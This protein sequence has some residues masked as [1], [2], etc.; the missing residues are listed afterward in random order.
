MRGRLENVEARL[1]EETGATPNMSEEKLREYAELFNGT[2]EVESFLF[3][4]DPHT[5]SLNNLTDIETKVSS[6][7]TLLREYY[8]NTPTSFAMCTGDWIDDGYTPEQACFNIGLASSLMRAWFDRCCYAVGNHEYNDCGTEVLTRQ[9]VHNLLLRDKAENYYVFDG[10][11]TK[12]YVL[13]TG[14][15]LWSMTE[16]GWEQID[17]LAN[18]LL[19]DNARFSAIVS[20]CWYI[21]DDAENLVLAPF[22]DTVLRLAQAYNTRATITLNDKEYSFASATGHVEFAIGGHK[23]T[24]KVGE[25]YGIP[26]ILTTTSAYTGTKATFDL[27]LADYTARKINFVRVGLGESRTVTLPDRA[28]VTV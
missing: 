2:E 12:F 9:T 17:W 13:D 3:F 14:R 24:D 20:H 6:E 5:I 11:R 1:D 8:E 18:V 19:T 15:L 27:V 22:A 23:H 28:D 4:T 21:A 26:V 10:D 7:L 16:Y 25:E